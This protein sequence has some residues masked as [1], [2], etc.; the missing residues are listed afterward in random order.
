M[1]YMKSIGIRELRQH[2]SHYLRLV[3]AGQTVQVTDRGKAIA[4][5]SPVPEGDGLDALLAMGSAQHGGGDL[6]DLGA[7]LPKK[8]GVPAPSVTLQAQRDSER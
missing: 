3:R 7:P 1:C 4:L 2:A 8:R 5:L 6:L